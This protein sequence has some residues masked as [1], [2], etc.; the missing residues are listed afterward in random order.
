MSFV[1]HVSEIWQASHF[2]V[3]TLHHIRSSLTTEAAKTIAVV[4]VVSRLDYYNFLLAD[5]FASNFARCM[6]VQNTIDRVV[7]QQF[8]HCHITPVLAGLHWLP[9]AF[10]SSSKW[11]Q[12]LSRFST[13]TGLCTLLKF[14]QDTHLLGHSTSKT[15]SVQFRKTWM[16]TST[17]V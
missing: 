6:M 16:A 12:L 11:P 15:T 5:T 1:E 7:T 2:H 3:R 8:R 10:G 4:I 13:I 14:F 17:S 9:T